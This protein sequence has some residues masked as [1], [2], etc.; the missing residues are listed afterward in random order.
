MDDSIQQAD[1]ALMR[2][3]KRRLNRRERRC[4]ETRERIVNAALQLFSERGVSATTVEDITNAADV[5]KGTFF[6]Y[7]PTKE[8]ILAYLCQMQMGK[9]REFVARALRSTESIDILL[10]KLALIITEK[11][12]YS[13]SLARNVLVPFFSNESARE[14]IARDFE[15]DRRILSELMAAGQDRGELRDDLTSEQLA[16]QFQRVFFGTTVLWSINPLRP[17]PDCL[18]EA[19]SVLWSGIRAS[20]ASQKNPDASERSEGGTQL[21]LK[22]HGREIGSGRTTSRKEKA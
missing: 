1:T 13:P 4:A 12:S 17:L 11:V 21:T 16:L 20:K 2:P 14:Q 3:H 6:N 5:G 10:Y 18:K 15:E 22:P 19:A 8:H 9:V 7:F